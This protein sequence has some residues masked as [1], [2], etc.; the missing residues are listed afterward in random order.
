MCQMTRVSLSSMKQDR[1]WTRLDTKLLHETR[2][3]DLYS[4]RMRSPDG[5][6][7]DDF[8]Y[9]KCP[10]WVVVIPITKQNEV[11]LVR[12]YRHGVNECGLEIPGGIM[13]ETGEDPGAAGLREMTEETGYISDKLTS[14]GFVHPNPALQSN[15][16]HF[17]L[18]EDAHP[19]GIQNL[20]PSED[21]EVV[22]EPLSAVPSLI[23]EGKIRHSLCVAAF[24]HYQLLRGPL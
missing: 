6:Y 22:V 18:A 24:C 13:S 21:I 20:D 3:F 17:Y 4:Q 23:K 9:L 12:Q 10:D 5:S 7:E 14:L 1:N 11:V 19:T 8:F 15:R 2:V 16:C